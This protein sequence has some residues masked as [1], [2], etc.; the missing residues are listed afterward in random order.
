MDR[1]NRERQKETLQYRERQ[2]RQ[3]K[4]QR[5]IDKTERDKARHRQN[6]KKIKI[7]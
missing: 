6:Q 4:I 3:S 1:K 5:K 7:D 2:I